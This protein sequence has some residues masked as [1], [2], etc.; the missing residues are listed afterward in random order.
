MK[1]SS[2]LFLPILNSLRPP[3]T[4]CTHDLLPPASDGSIQMEFARVGL[5]SNMLVEM[6]YGLTSAQEIQAAKPTESAARMASSQLGRLTSLVR[7][8]PCG[9]G[10]FRRWLRQN[11]A[12]QTRLALC[13][14]LSFGIFQ[15]QFSPQFKHALT[16]LLGL[17]DNGRLQIVGHDV[18][19]RSEFCIV[20]GIFGT[21]AILVIVRAVEDFA[22]RHHAQC[23]SNI[24][25]QKDTEIRISVQAFD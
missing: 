14:H 23:R 9:R 4:C 19:K 13:Y 17:A 1:H 22:K 10:L 25:R 21:Q 5:L 15:T 3:Q 24:L 8:G 16:Q 18:A 7:H 11:T 2:Y 20:V 6:N 12:R